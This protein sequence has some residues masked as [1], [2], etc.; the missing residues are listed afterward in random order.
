MIRLIRT[1]LQTVLGTK[2]TIN[3]VLARWM[4]RRRLHPRRHGP[5]SDPE[6]SATGSVSPG[7]AIPDNDPAGVSSTIEIVEDI[8]IEW[9]EII[10]NITHTYRGNLEMKLISPSGT[11]SILTEPHFDSGKQLSKLDA[12]FGS[13]L[14]RKFDRY[15]EIG[16]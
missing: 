6:V 10:P 2:S 7:L 11:E 4:L 14:G 5:R 15:L 1:G 16:S 3:T 13:S 9:I 8:L 12:N